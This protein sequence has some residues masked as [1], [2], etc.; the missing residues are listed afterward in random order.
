MKSKLFISLNL[1]L[2]VSL[3]LIGCAKTKESKKAEPKGYISDTSMLTEDPEG[4]FSLIYVND[5]IDWNSYDKV[6]IQ[7]VT[8]YV[9]KGSSLEK[10]PEEK[11]QKMVEYMQQALERELSKD[12]EIVTEGGP[13]V[14]VFRGAF[15]EISDNNTL[16]DTVTTV[17]PPA[18]A[19]SELKNL[20][21]GKHAGVGQ[22]AYEGEVLDGET[23]ERIAAAVSV[24]S[25][26]KALK[27][28]FDNQRDVR[29][30]IDTWAVNSRERLE[31]VR[32][33]SAEMNK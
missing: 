27:T 2:V 7:T 25:G 12:Y 26:G 31:I 18:R 29:A 17:A 19:F 8:A 28:N 21:T 16:V 10:I 9:L 14:M 11:I 33:K 23:G 13:G 3:I 5:Q 22:A 32:L 24:R 4:K 1:L 15:T 20:V 30:A 6:W